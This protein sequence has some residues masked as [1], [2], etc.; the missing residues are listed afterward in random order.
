MTVSTHDVDEDS[1]VRRISDSLADALNT[2][3]GVD[4]TQ[5]SNDPDSPQTISLHGHDESQTAVTLDGIPLSAPGTAANLRG[6]NTDL[7]T[8]ASASFG[9]RA[10][11][12]GG[13]VN[14]TTLQPTQTW[15]YRLSA[16]DGS[17]DKYNWSVGVT[18]S[19]GKLGIAAL[20]TKRG[21]NNPL[22]FQDYL[23]ASGLDLPARRREHERR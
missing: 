14:F 4:V 9:A 21:G 17:F 3:A 19:V 16:A 22:T 2:L 20:T 12:L 13:G 10:G 5:S 23:D 15:Q 11:A 18:G 7:F 1:A 8:G 6:I